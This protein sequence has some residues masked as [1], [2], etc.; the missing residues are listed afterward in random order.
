MQQEKPLIFQAP[1]H[2]AHKGLVAGFA[3]MLEHAH[4]HNTVKG[5]IQV[6]VILEPDL[7]RQST[8]PLSGQVHLF[9][10]YGDTHYAYLICPG[11]ICGQASPSATDIQHPHPRRQL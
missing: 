3:H 4:G 9:F 7:H 2:H 5:F 1:V 10:R 8:A 6:P 11:H